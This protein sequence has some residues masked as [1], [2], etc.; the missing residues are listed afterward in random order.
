MYLVRRYS[1]ISQND[2]QRLD[3]I[4]KGPMNTR[5]SSAIDGI[6]SIRAYAKE[7]YFIDKFMI[8]SDLNA[9][10]KFTYNGIARWY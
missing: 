9:S 7:Q 4:T 1:I 3:A 6:T 2:T 10:A 5:Y 8:D